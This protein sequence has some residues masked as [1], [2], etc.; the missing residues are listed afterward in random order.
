MASNIKVLREKHN[1][2]TRNAVRT[3]GHLQMLMDGTNTPEHVKPH[4][5][6]CLVV[7]ERGLLG[8]DMEDER[9]VIE[10]IGGVAYV[11]SKTDYV[12][13]VIRDLDNEMEA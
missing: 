7:L 12:D 10:V 11:T 8:Q 3:V 9:V 13:V 1:L 4:V 2:L 6:A 5:L